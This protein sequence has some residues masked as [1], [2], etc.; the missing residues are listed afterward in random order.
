MTMNYSYSAADFGRVAVLLGGN[1]AERVISLE[2][3]NSVLSALQ[4]AGV[5]AFGFDTQNRMISELLDENVDRVFIALHGRGGEDG[6]I[7]GAL[8]SLN[9][10]YTGSGILGSALAMDKIRS[11]QLW[12]SSGLATPEY[13]PLHAEMNW[14]ALAEDLGLPLIVK[15]AR[16]GSSL[17]ISKV[18]TVAELPRAWEKASALDEYVIAERWIE[19]GGEFTIPILAN[20]ALPMIRLETPR[21]FYDYQAKYELDTTQYICP[22]G[23]EQEKETEI[24][25]LALKAF[26]ALDCQD[27][28]RV[29]VLID[30]EGKAWLIEANTVPGMTSHSLVPMSAKQQGIDFGELVLRILADTMIEKAM[31]S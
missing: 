25:T 12:L 26:A 31:E 8:E 19:G 24:A 3:G 14:Q 21:E 5:N 4:S 1:S 28:G 27:W 11:K 18:K 17:G 6:S 20:Q 29:D 22:C 23:L 10:P 9:I 2:S 13:Q 16:E 7:Q 15:P 30:G